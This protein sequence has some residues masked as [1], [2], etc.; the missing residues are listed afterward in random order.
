MHARCGPVM[1]VGSRL[2]SPTVMSNAFTRN[3]QVTIRLIR[4]RIE[5][6]PNKTFLLTGSTQACPPAREY[7]QH[8]V[9]CSPMS[10]SIHAIGTTF[11]VPSGNAAFVI[12]GSTYR[13]GLNQMSR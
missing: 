5:E 10:K 11:V 9:V 1:L 3:V 13:V 6:Q 4:R 8:A 12:S 2:P 7:P